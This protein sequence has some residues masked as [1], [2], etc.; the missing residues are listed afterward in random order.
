M[1]ERGHRLRI[2]EEGIVGYAINVGRPRIAL[3]VGADS[4]YFDNPDLPKTRSEMALPLRL[5]S[6]YIGALDIQSTKENAFSNEDIAVFTTLADQIAIAIQNANLLKQAQ[7]A[8]REVEEAYAEQ[9]GRTWR[10]FT[11]N[12]PVLG[13]RYDG[14]E[15]KPLTS[16]DQAEFKFEAGLTFPMSLRGKTIGKL[17]LR[18]GDTDRSWTEEEISIINAAIGRAALALENARLLENA[19]KRA[20]RERAIGEITTNIGASTDMEAIL[21]AA[22]SELGQQISGAK[23]AVEL[24][25]EIEQEES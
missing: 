15:S 11:K 5:G 17:K 24:N 16:K 19:Q 12:Q 20:A 1:L 4:V 23:I 10:E 8:L 7:S 3:D 21:R 13:Y 2:G 9:T 6:E 22:V 18:T 25:T 14:A